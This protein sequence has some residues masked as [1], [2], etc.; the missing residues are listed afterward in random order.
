MEKKMK[1][2]VTS[3]LLPIVLLFTSCAKNLDYSIA[4]KNVGTKS[5]W[6]NDFFINKKQKI[7][8]G[9]LPPRT[10]KTT[11]TIT[12]KPDKIFPITW[13][14]YQT[15][16]RGF[17]EVKMEIPTKFWQGRIHNGVIINLNPDT[18][19]A[20]IKYTAYSL[21]ED[22]DYSISQKDQEP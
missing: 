3:M 10:A 18:A 12:T 6:V 9:V 22:K 1:L 19:T 16:Q 21:K 2:M 11:L 5:I 14:D 7:G 8:V 4:V 13:N 17:L 15:K 20:E